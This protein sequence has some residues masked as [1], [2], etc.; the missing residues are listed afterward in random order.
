MDDRAEALRRRIAT[1]R[2]YLAEGIPT[3][4]AREYLSEIAKAEAELTMIARE[5]AALAKNK[6]DSDKPE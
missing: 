1:C 5:E 4:F 3:V 6:K 2:L